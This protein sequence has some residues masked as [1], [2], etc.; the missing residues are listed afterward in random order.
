MKKNDYFVVVY[1]LLNYFYKCLQEG[2]VPNLDEFSPDALGINNTY[3]CNI[4]DDLVCD[5]YVRGI[6]KNQPMGLSLINPRITSKG[7]AYLQQDSLMSDA[8]ISLDTTKEIVLG[9]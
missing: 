3:W 7:I 6:Y 5:G 8:R 2:E 1:R 4:M 9:F